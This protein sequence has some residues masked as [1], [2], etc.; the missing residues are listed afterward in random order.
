MVWGGIWETEGYKE[1]C[2][3]WERA[4][5]ILSFS[6]LSDDW[7]KASSKMMPPHSAI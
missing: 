4:I 7:S 1:R 5:A 6:I 3:K 2:N